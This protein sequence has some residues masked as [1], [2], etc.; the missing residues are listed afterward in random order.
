[1]KHE[2]N[3]GT[4]LFLSKISLQT[5]KNDIPRRQDSHRSDVGTVINNAQ[6]QSIKVSKMQSEY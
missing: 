1:M 6:D 2:I 5:K 4:W 3:Q